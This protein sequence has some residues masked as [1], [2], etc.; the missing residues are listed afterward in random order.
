M[1][2]TVSVHITNPYV[3]TLV[4]QLVGQ[5]LANLPARLRPVLLNNPANLPPAAFLAQVGGRPYGTGFTGLGSLD[6][7]KQNAKSLALFT[8]N[9]WHATDALDLTLGLRY[10]RQKKDLASSYSN[11]NGSLA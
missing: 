4:Y 9:T 6:R 3:S 11:P 7:Y 10:T 1:R 8:S 2:R 5:G